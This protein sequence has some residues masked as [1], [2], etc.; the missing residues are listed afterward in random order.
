GL[1]YYAGSQTGSIVV[2]AF[3][4]HTFTGVSSRTVLMPNM[5]AQPYFLPLAGNATYFVR[6]FVDYNGDLVR[7]SS[8][9]A[10]SFNTAAA[11]HPIALLAGP[12]TGYDFSIAADTVAPAIPAGLKA[13]PGLR[14]VTLSWGGV[15]RNADGSNITDLAG[16]I[17]QRTTVIG[18]NPAWTSLFSAPLSTTVYRDYSPL[19]WVYNYYR[20]LAVDIG[21]NQSWPSGSIQALPSQGG[22][23]NGT[24]ALYTAQSNG[25]LRVRL[26]TAPAPN[27]PFLYESVVS[28]FSFTGLDDNSTGYFL[29]AFLDS[30]ND[31]NMDTL[32]DPSGAFGGLNSAYPIPV[33]NAGMVPNVNVALCDRIRIAVSS[34]L[35]GALASSDCPA[36]DKGP[37]YYADLYAFPVGDGSAGSLGWGSQIRIKMWA[38]GTAYD[39]ELILLAPDGTLAARDNRLGGA[40]LVATVTQRG[41]YLVEA[42]SYNPGPAGPYSIALDINGGFSGVVKGSVAYSGAQAGA[43]KVQLFNSPDAAA[44]PI[45]VLTMPAFISPAYFEFPGLVDG[46]YYVRAYRDANAN[47]VRDP[48]EAAGAFGVSLS[49]PSAVAVTGGISNQAAGVTVT[50]TDPAVGAVKGGVLYD[51][52]QPGS[53]RVEIG[54]CASG[55]S[56]CDEMRELA[57]SAV[58][59][60]GA[61]NSYFIGFLPPATNYYL[62]AFVD[63]NDS[64]SPDVLEPKASS[65]PVTVVAGSS[66]T[67]SLIL[68]DPGSG[69]AGDGTLRGTA[70]YAGTKTGSIMIGF[71]R[72]SN[73]SFMDYTVVMATTGAFIKPGVLGG[74][75]YYMA[76]FIDV[77]GNGN[78]DDITGEP[79]NVGA[80]EGF[81]GAA[82]YSNPPAIYVPLSGATT[83][84]ITFSDP[85]TGELRGRVTYS[86][87]APWDKRLVIQA[88]IPGSSGANS[89]RQIFIPRQ[90]GINDYDYAMRFLNASPSYLV[91]A[92]VDSNSNDRSDYGEPMGNYG[93]CYAAGSCGSPV[94]V[95]SGPN[96]Y[97]AYGIDFAVSDPGSFGSGM[98][99]GRIRGDV[100]YMGL[101]D[102]PIVVR[103]FD[104][105]EYRGLPVYALSQSLPP[106]P[107]EI[108]FDQTLLAFGTYYL[109][110]YRGYGDY[111]PTYHAYG[112]LNNGAALI[113][114]QYQP[115]AWS[116]Y[117]SIT[118]PGAGGSVNAF[119]GDFSAPAGA[120]F[121]GG[122]TDIS[123]VVIATGSYVYTIGVT[124]QFRGIQT[125]AVRYDLSG[126]MVS[127]AALYDGDE[128]YGVPTVDA[129]TGAMYLGSEDE[130]QGSFWYSTGTIS[131]YD[132]GLGLVRKAWFPGHGRMSSLMFWNG[133]LYAAANDA[134]NNSNVDVLKIDPDTFV[135]VDTGTVTFPGLTDLYPDTLSLGLDSAGNVYFYTV[136]EKDGDLKF[137]FLVKMAADLDSYQKADITGTSFPRNYGGNLAVAPSGDVYLSGTPAAADAAGDFYAVTYKFDSELVQKAS[138]AYTPILKHFSGGMGNIAVAPGSGD[139][140]QAWETPANGGDFAVLRYDSNLALISSRTFDG[141]NNTLEDFPFSVAVR[142]INN[143]FVTGGV[144]NGSTLDFATVKLDMAA[145]GAVSAAGQ[146]VV[147]T[148]QNATRALWGSLVY[149]G[150][151]VA[152]GTVRA[153][154]FGADPINPGQETLIRSSTAAFGASRPYLFNNLQAGNYRIQAFIDPNEN[155]LPD[156]GEPVAQTTAT[157]VYFSTFTLGSFNLSFCDRLGIALDQELSGSLQ[158]GDCAAWDHQGFPQKLYTFSGRRG[159]PVTVT[160]TAVGFYDS[161]LMLYGPDGR[162]LISDDE[163]AGAGNAKINN[164]VLPADGLYAIAAT[165]NADVTGGFKLALKGSQAT[166]GSISGTVE[167]LGSQGGKIMA[168]LFNSPSYSST[169]YITGQVLA[170]T[171]NFTFSGLPTGTTYYLGAFVDVNNNLSAD[172]GEDGNDYGSTPDNGYQ[173][174]PISLQSGQNVSG[175]NITIYPSLA[176]HQAYFTGNIIY[177]GARFGTVRVELWPSADFSGRPVAVRDL[178]NGA[179]PYDAAAPGG[180]SYFIRAYMDLNGNFQSD[181]DEPKGVYS[182]NNQ[183][184]QPLY[185][186]P[187]SQLVNVDVV[188]RDPW[189]ASSGLGAS[190]EGSAAISPNT[191]AAGAQL[192]V[193]TIT[194]TAGA[195]GIAGNGKVGFVV[196]PGFAWP[197]WVVVTATVAAPS[198]ATV[199]A[200]SFSGQGAFVAVDPGGWL[201]PGEQIRFVYDRVWVPCQLST[202]AFSVVSAQNDLVS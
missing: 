82:D 53:L 3:T 127:S 83:A 132:S 182:P 184:A 192:F 48:G 169:A 155:L 180:V 80:P 71:S 152:S 147:I 60:T 45:Q 76:G 146:T 33:W 165:A 124:K 54:R 129:A 55:A 51:G 14:L 56:T 183:G 95:S 139:I 141:R 166:L 100:S 38:Q 74:A 136:M 30:N 121:D 161:Y 104:N 200:V 44:L 66:I 114:S 145:V 69:S 70:G 185:A 116:Q 162:I 157:G 111:N 123:A 73:F 41:V 194:Y 6:A 81:S 148:T 46:A 202:V 149:A 7:Q 26:S 125:V 168:A 158:A 120:R 88:W 107:G 186:G 154:L 92:F 67:I 36:L 117:G 1:L 128:I 91:N 77:N 151:A 98:N 131:K 10:G 84:N 163:G 130:T 29:R 181:P 8:E 78:P 2:Q 191:A 144:N 65:G 112:R 138:A 86:G 49:S 85:P 199:S 172:P 153:M 122:A 150:S 195:N 193:A 40:V 61:A 189:A 28:S 72:T 160:L 126:V 96:T 25:Q 188:I 43:V 12:A 179:G 164:F 75:T 4:T 19:P 15:L 34:P 18:A 101:Q 94:A 93:P 52:A 35:A 24:V 175:A 115:Q 87:S 37:G 118:D 113:V 16:Y 178:P 9:A 21:N 64:K 47:L 5:A 167:Y 39:T 17:V 32:I 50:M 22:A 190:G 134:G 20:V 142:D 174:A 57:V 42:T 109:D 105:P 159:Q 201:K 89:S 198:T 13:T 23:I 173:K 31:G 110:A 58:T 143:V 171:R 170:S 62:R 63:S 103:F 197:Q 137:H 176:S 140:I 187:N 177:S 99:G 156:A 108:A 27:S 135:T 119:T 102:G 79:T 90:A 133:Y 59:S 97:P 68:R 106:G 196:P 11:P